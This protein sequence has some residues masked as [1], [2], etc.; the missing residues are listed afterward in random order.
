MVVR[1]CGEVAEPPLEEQLAQGTL[2][3]EVRKLWGHGNNVQAA[4]CHGALLASA[5]ESKTA[6]L[7]DIWLW[8]TQVN[9]N[10]LKA[11]G[12][13]RSGDFALVLLTS[14]N[15]DYHESYKYLSS[16]HYLLPGSKEKRGSS[17]RRKFCSW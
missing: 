6:D 17:C 4:A 1:L 16:S 2:W 10:A 5:A 15:L 8:D 12:R 11:L 9:A 13:E 14:S 7:A 3:P